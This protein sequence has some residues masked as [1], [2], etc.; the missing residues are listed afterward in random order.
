M[1][2]TSDNN[3]FGVNFVNLSSERGFVLIAAVLACM[4][5]LAV[6]IL[7]LTM[8]GQDVKISS[9]VVGEKKAFSACE[10]GVHKLTTTLDPENLAGSAVTNVQVDSTNDSASLYTIGMPSRPSTGPGMLPLSGYSIGGGQVWG[11]TLYNATVTGTN[12]DYDSRVQISIGI[13]YGPIEM[14]TISR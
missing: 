14:T 2:S 10:S 6:G 11:Q 13:G 4:I 5:L 9:R 1:R 7:A 3:R 12:T 8:S